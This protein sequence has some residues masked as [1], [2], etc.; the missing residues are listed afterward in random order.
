MYIVRIILYY[1]LYIVYK[2]NMCLDRSVVYDKYFGAEGCRFESIYTH[3]IWI[4]ENICNLFLTFFF[5]LLFWSQIPHQSVGHHM[6][7]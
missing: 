7:N 6:V 1:I 5:C 4:A 2:K 3:S